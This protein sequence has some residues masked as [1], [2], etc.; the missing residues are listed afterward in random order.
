MKAVQRY[1]LP[2]IRLN[3]S[4]V[5]YNGMKIMNTAV[6][7]TKV[8]RV[9]PKSSHHKKNIFFFFFNFVSAR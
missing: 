3:T 7:Y 2:V 4:D 6:L 1:K 5:A 9:N 8:K